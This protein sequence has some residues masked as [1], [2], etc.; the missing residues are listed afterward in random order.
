VE[1]GGVQRLV[2]EL[3]ALL[4]ESGGKAR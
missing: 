1:Q 4:A 2:P 3:V